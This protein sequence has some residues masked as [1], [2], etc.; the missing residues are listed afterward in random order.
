MITPELGHIYRLEDPEYGRLHCLAVFVKEFPGLE[1]SFEALRVTVTSQRLDFPH[2][3]RLSSGD[4]CTGY[5]VLYHRERVDHEEIAED[6]GPLSME[7]WVDVRT[8]LRRL[9]GL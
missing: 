2:W 6:L 1:K 8:S 3:K 4:P 9:W 7:S 5:V